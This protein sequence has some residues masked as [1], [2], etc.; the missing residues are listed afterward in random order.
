M[1]IRGSQE[2]SQKASK[3]KDNFYELKSDDKG[4]LQNSCTEVEAREYLSNAI[5]IECLHKYSTIK[6]LFCIYNAVL[7]SSAPVERLFSVGYAVFTPKQK[8]LTDEKLEKL[9]LMCYNKHL[10]MI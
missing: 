4:S 6:K 10:Y 9:L 2:E 1:S 8:R 5:R 3:K 7:L